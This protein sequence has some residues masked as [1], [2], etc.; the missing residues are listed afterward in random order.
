MN[1][2]KHQ[3]KQNSK[4]NNNNNRK[5]EL[6]KEIK[7]KLEKK[8]AIKNIEWML[9]HVRLTEASGMGGDGGKMCMEYVKS[10]SLLSLESDMIWTT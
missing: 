6:Q 10:F 4:H 7:I 8:N 3:K 2:T 5:N 1:E 9:A